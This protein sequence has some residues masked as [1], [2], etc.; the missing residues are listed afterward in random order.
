M[1]NA[2]PAEMRAALSA[3]SGLATSGLLQF[4]C[5]GQ[6]ELTDKLTPLSSKFVDEMV[7][8][9]IQPIDMLRESVVISSPPQLRPEDFSHV[10]PVWEVI[11]PYLDG[12]LKA[13]KCGV[14]V[15]LH[16]VPGTGK[17]Q[18]ARVLASALNTQLFEVTS[19][20]AEGDSISGVHRLQAYRAAQSFLARQRALILF[21]EVEDVFDEPEP[22]FGRRKAASSKA[23]MNRTLE[24]NAVPALWIT[25]SVRGMDPA[26]IRRFDIVLEMPVPDR[27][28]VV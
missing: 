8:S 2:D 25:N 3:R 1:L 18:F 23:W 15:L 19:E 27:K 12:T 6:S 20:D 5:S 10:A 13:G 16:G 7:H 21:D 24:A 26:V 11:V 14:N 17:T 4:D 22:M 9:D 28:S